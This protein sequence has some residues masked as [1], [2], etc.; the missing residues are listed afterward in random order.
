MAARPR[1]DLS[2]SPRISSVRPRLVCAVPSKPAP[3]SPL[4]SFE[5]VRK[6]PSPGMPS[7]LAIS[8]G[9]LV[10]DAGAVGMFI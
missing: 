1:F 2:V 3:T 8:S 5:A 10:T 7:V 9:S 6:K 4:P